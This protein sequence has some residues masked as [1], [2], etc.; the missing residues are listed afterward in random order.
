[1]SFTEKESPIS[2]VPF[3][4]V[5]ICPETKASRDKLDVVGGYHNIKSQHM[6]LTDIE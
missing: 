2:S 4:T 6:N 3:P 1:M 5:T